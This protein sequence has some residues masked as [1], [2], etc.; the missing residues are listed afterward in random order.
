MKKLK[1]YESTVKGTVHFTND[2]LSGI[3][4]KFYHVEGDKFGLE[5]VLP[6]SVMDRIDISKMESG[7]HAKGYY[8]MGRLMEVASVL[9]KHAVMH[10]DCVEVTNFDGTK[11][12]V[13][14]IGIDKMLM[15]MLSGVAQEQ[16][17]K[18]VAAGIVPEGMTFEEWTE[19][20]GPEAGAIED[21]KKRTLH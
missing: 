6:K 15:E 18:E 11:Q 5:L 8:T 20:A 9:T 4:I 16:Y 19:V 7:E 14:D 17:D 2:E 10:P 13:K 21:I 3:H 1:D 12:S